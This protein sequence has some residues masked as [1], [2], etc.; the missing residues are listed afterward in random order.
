VEGATH[1]R[2]YRAAVEEHKV[3]LPE[4]FRRHLGR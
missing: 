3:R 1:G 4:F 2:C